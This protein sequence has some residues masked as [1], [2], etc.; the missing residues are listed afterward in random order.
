MQSSISCPIL[1]DEDKKILCLD[2]SKEIVD[3][4][5][6]KVDRNDHEIINSTEEGIAAPL[7]FHSV[8]SLIPESDTPN[9]LIECTECQ[10]LAAT[11]GSLIQ[12]EKMKHRGIKFPCVLCDFAGE[13]F[14]GL[15]EHIESVHF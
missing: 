5:K 15:Y 14:D 8:E 3:E 6:I 7:G 13:T 12:H 2:N 9:V 11:A 4:K 1:L 10:F